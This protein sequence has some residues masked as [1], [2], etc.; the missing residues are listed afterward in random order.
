MEK[1]QKKEESHNVHIGNDV[2]IMPG[3]T[4]GDNS[5]IAVGAVV[6]G[7]IPENSIYGGVPARFIETLDEYINKHKDDF[8][9]TKYP[10]AE[11]KK[12]SLLKNIK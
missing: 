6:T 8:D 11:S 10:N 12:L 7:N 1:H 9:Y 4:I 3:V 5:I 2:H